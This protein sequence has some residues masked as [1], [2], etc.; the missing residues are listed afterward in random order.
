MFIHPGHFGMN[1]CMK[2]EKFI[3]GY[4]TESESMAKSDEKL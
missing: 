2:Q 4:L 3:R 1:D